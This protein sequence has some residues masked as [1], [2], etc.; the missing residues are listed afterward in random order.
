[1][2]TKTQIHP[3]WKTFA[4]A[5][6]MTNEASAMAELQLSR[7]TIDRYRSGYSYPASDRVCGWAISTI[8]K[9]TYTK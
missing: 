4:L 6:N 9:H 1:M 7:K 8:A 3:S 5:L 2:A